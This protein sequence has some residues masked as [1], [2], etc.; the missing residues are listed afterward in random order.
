MKFKCKI[1]YSLL[2][3]TKINSWLILEDN[4][5]GNTNKTKSRKYFLC[6][7]LEVNCDTKKLVNR[8]DLINN[9]TKNCGC[10]RK[11]D[12]AGKHIGNWFVVMKTKFDKTTFYLCR[13]ICG[14]EK[15]VAGSQLMAG[16]SKSCGCTN[17]IDTIEDAKAATI[18]SIFGYKGRKYSDGNITIDQFTKLINLP[19]FYCTRSNVNMQNMSKSY[20]SQFVKDN[21]DVKY[22][23]LDKFISGKGTKHNI[24]NVVPCCPN[25]NFFKL[26]YTY[27]KVINKIPNLKINPKIITVKDLHK[28]KDKIEL[29]N[30]KLL[31]TFNDKSTNILGKIFPEKH[32]LKKDKVSF[33]IFSARKPPA[34]CWW[35][36]C[37]PLIL[38]FFS[39]K[40]YA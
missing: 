25:C 32:L 22:N 4:I 34:L 9:R 36:N 29:F 31:E 2:I 1:D 17:R 3:G 39:V 30:S 24:D 27:E 20:S 19:C 8:V 18:R 38:S 28:V 7:C 13:C 12:I 35:R 37:Q 6:K 11:K 16:S 10:T 33:M 26:N 21:S 23:G 15:E 40:I 5:S 14:K